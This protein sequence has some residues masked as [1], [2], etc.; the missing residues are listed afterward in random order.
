MTLTYPLVVLS[1]RAAVETK[2]THVSLTQAVAKIVKEEGLEGLYS[3]LSSSLFGIS[4]TNAVFY[5][6]YEESKAILLRARIRNNKSTAAAT[7]STFESILSSVI[8]GSLTTIATNPLWLIQTRQATKRASKRDETVEGAPKPVSKQLNMFSAMMD[9]IRNDGGISALW[10]GIGPALILVINP[11]LQYTAFEQLSRLLLGFRER[12]GKA[13]G[14]KRSLSDLDMFWLG[15]L[16][17][18]FA[19]GL[20]YPYVLVKS[21]LHAS[22]HQYASSFSALATIVKAEGISG[23]YKGVAPKLMQSVSTAAFLFVFQRRVYEL[24]KLAIRLLVLRSQR[25]VV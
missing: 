17:K 6:T 14:G 2:K 21:R 13:L 24:V 16:A 23:L 9:I 19:T 1:T 22:T 20:T 11:V 18:L 4:I 8:A 15:A 3:G 25:K 12:K 10:K 7:L 5:F